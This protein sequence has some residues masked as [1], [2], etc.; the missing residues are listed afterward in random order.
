M[1]F[2][3]CA[4]EDIDPGEKNGMIQFL[5]RQATVLIKPAHIRC[6]KEEKNHVKFNYEIINNLN[7]KAK[8]FK[9]LIT[10][11]FRLSALKCI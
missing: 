4:K 8:C 10:I 11:I 1:F 3:L 7:V 5:T 2:F 6:R 9:G